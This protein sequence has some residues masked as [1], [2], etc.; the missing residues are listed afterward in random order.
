MP[1]KYRIRPE[2]FLDALAARGIASAVQLAQVAEIAKGTA[3]RVMRGEAVSRAV[4]VSIV[5]GLTNETT[6]PAMQVV[7]SELFEAAS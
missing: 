3:E 1:E 5:T 4:V 2:R 7:A 6:L